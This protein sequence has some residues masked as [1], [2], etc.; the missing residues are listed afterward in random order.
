MK[1]LE[2][3]PKNRDFILIIL[4]LM[5]IMVVL[6]GVMYMKKEESRCLKSP[7]T[8]SIEK[9]SQDTNQDIACVCNYGFFINKTTIIK[10]V[11][12][13]RPKTALD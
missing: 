12:P 13:Y 6:V 3:N 7:Y 11:V 8:Y 10:E 5:L 2:K 4:L 1:S 9:L